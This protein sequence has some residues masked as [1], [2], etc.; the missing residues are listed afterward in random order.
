M[1]NDLLY[2]K[3]H[4]LA[5]NDFVER[6]FKLTTREL[7]AKSPIDSIRSRTG[8]TLSLLLVKKSLIELLPCTSDYIVDLQG[9]CEW[10][11]YFALRHVHNPAVFYVTSNDISLDR[12]VSDVMFLKV[13]D[14]SWYLRTQ[15][16]LKNQ[17][18][19]ELIQQFPNTDF[20][21]LNLR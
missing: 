10:P 2:D 3:A 8:N 19:D 16:Y 1:T 17:I 5:I 7:L 4:F 6:E 14:A 18:V 12:P 13:E 9:L 21:F 11:S 15:N 20:S